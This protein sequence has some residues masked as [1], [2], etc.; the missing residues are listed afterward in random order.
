[1]PIYERFCPACQQTFTVT[2]TIREHDEK[3]PVCPTCG[4]KELEVVFGSVFTKTTRKA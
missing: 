1:M 2:L 3:P 4:S